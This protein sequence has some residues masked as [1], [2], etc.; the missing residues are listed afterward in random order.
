MSYTTNE[1]VPPPMQVMY[2][3]CY[4]ERSI[5]P[6]CMAA[7]KGSDANLAHAASQSPEISKSTRYGWMATDYIENSVGF[8]ADGS[9]FDGTPEPYELVEGYFKDKRIFAY[10]ASQKYEGIVKDMKAR[11]QNY[12]DNQ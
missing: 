4:W 8:V 11:H 7:F 6:F 3:V 12:K 1:N 2:G 9:S 5:D 10:P